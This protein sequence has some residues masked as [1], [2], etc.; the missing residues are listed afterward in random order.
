MPASFL[1]LDQQNRKRIKW[2][3]YQLCLATTL[4]ANDMSRIRVLAIATSQ[5]CCD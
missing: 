5:L 2:N 4:E 1:S 3:L